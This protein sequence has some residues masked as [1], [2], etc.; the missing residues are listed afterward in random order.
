LRST[1][2]ERKGII[3]ESVSKPVEDR[4][5]SYL[6]RICGKPL[7]SI[8][9]TRDFAA[10]TVMPAD[11]GH[12]E[13]PVSLERMSGG[14]KEQIHL[15]TRLALAEELMREQPHFLLLDDVLTATD[16]TRLRRVCDMLSEFS[17]HTQVIL[18][19]CHPERFACISE[20]NLID[21]EAVGRSYEPGHHRETGMRS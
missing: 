8:R 3:L 5:T 4:A 2:L 9:M 1:L 11:M 7:A 17:R 19:T 6:A 15:C 12:S 20:A 16:S 21:M 18:F 13:E 10:E 14:E